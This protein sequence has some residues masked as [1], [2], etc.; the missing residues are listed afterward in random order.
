MEIDR[1]FEE[2][3]EVKE[4]H[5]GGGVS[6]DMIV[7]LIIRGR[8]LFPLATEE[9]PCEDASGRWLSASQEESSPEG[10]NLPAP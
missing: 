9:R 10:P 8:A 2:V 6:S 7:G 4:G 3:T 5:L 1:T